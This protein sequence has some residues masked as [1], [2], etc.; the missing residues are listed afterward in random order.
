MS[1]RAK[2]SAKKMGITTLATWFG[3]NRTLAA[4]VGAALCG[5]KWIGVPFA[6]G[7]SEVRCIEATSVLV[8]D[9][10]RHVINLARVAAHPKLGPMLIRRL[11]RRF[12]HSE[13]LAESQRV[14]RSIEPGNVPD[15]DAAEH[16][17]VA[18]WQG[19]SARG[20]LES[21]LTGGACIRWTGN[22]GSSATR[23]RSATES[24]AGWR[25]VFRRCDFTVMDVFDF[26]DRVHDRFQ[27][28]IYC[29]PPFPGPGDR[30]AHTLTEG[31]Q[32]QLANKLASFAKCRV[33]CRFYDHPLIRELY[34]ETVW[35]WNRFDGR[36]QTNEAGPEVLLELARGKQ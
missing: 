24:L 7:M 1:A 11:R 6:G 2:P 19:R 18:V 25:D 29:D 31:Q 12:M 21:E 4:N 14:A 32:V 26:L 34:P 35:K 30:Y 5:C 10:H 15:L 13:E 8:N 17:F 28:G 27:H 20:G 36:K 9:L 23:F 33:V 16:Y 3:S 22:G